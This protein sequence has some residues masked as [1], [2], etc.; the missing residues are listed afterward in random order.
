MGDVYDLNWSFQ[1]YE[2][3]VIKRFWGGICWGIE[4]FLF[5]PIRMNNFDEGRIQ[6]LDPKRK[7]IINGPI[8]G[9]L[10]YSI[11]IFTDGFFVLK[12]RL[13]NGML[14]GEILAESKGIFVSL[15]EK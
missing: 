4:R 8:I 15:M 5:H 3:G 12:C 6:F 11:S 10:T 9:M 14:H 7:P 1:K 2:C 13:E